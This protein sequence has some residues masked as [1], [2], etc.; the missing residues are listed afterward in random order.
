MSAQ[1]KRQSNDPCP[2]KCAPQH[3]VRELKTW[4]TSRNKMIESCKKREIKKTNNANHNREEVSNLL[5][6]ILPRRFFLLL[7]IFSSGERTHFLRI[8]II[9]IKK[10]TIKEHKTH[11]RQDALGS[12]A[13]KKCAHNVFRKFISQLFAALFHSSSSSSSS[14]CVCLFLLSEKMMCSVHTTSKQK[15]RNT[16]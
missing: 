1:T 2:Q 3:G 8:E 16:K 9:I 10:G 11:E 7:F 5:L 15:K 13:R 6:S 14:C 4:K 12:R